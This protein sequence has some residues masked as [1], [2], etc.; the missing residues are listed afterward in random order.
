MKEKFKKIIHDGLSKAKAKS[1]DIYTFALYHDHESHFATVCIDTIESS[2]RSVISSNEFSKKYFMRSIM[3]GE[4]PSPGAW[5]A[6]GGRSFSLGDFALVNVS[7]VKVA[8]LPKLPDFYIDMVLAIE[9]TRALIEKQS[10]HG[11]QLLY[12]CSTENNEVGLVWS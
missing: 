2:K 6:N 10:T 7:E 1:V 3:S 5:N 8:R 9:E 11:P 12:C 4:L